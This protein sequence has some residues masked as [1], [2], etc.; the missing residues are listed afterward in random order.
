MSEVLEKSF[1]FPK[2][3]GSHRSRGIGTYRTLLLRS[4]C[5][6]MEISST[7][8]LILF[9]RP[10]GC[11]RFGACLQVVVIGKAGPFIATVVEDGLPSPRS[12][13]RGSRC[14]MPIILDN[15]VT[16]IGSENTHLS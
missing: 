16:T 14:M 5:W 1:H 7:E 15:L 11:G 9:F 10:R 12:T 8:I 13:R 4:R 2:D 6:F 3:L